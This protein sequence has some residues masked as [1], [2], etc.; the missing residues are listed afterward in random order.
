MEGGW[1][2]TPIYLKKGGV[3]VYVLVSAEAQ[4][5]KEKREARHSYSVSSVRYIRVACGCGQGSGHLFYFLSDSSRFKLYYCRTKQTIGA[6][7][8]G[9][10]KF[11]VMQFK[12]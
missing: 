7:Y 10:A 2:A 12:N 5:I 1:G 6:E 8:S 4:K 11:I 9:S 3:C